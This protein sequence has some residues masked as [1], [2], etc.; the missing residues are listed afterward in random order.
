M[1]SGMQNGSQMR[2]TEDEQKLIKSVY[3]NNP[4]L[5]LLLRKMFLPEIDP[6]APIGSAIDLWMT[7]KLEDLSPEDAL[8]NI[9]ARNLL[10]SHIDQRLMEI[11]LLSKVNEETEDQKKARL[12]K[13]NLR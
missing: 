6:Q 4:A 12:K 9:K 1:N 8:V 10:I 2:I 3:G 7:M 11:S 5:V 13:D